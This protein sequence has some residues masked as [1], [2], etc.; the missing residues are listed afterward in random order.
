MKKYLGILIWFACLLVSC[1]MPSFKNSDSFDYANEAAMFSYAPFDSSRAVDFI[2][3]TK[4]ISSSNITVSWTYFPGADKYIIERKTEAG[5]WVRIYI[6]NKSERNFKDS[7]SNG[8]MENIDYL[9]R[10]CA[11]SSYGEKSAYSDVATGSLLSAPLNVNVTKGDK[12]TNGIKV[13]W[14]KVDGITTYNIMMKPNDNGDFL[15]WHKV[16]TVK[17]V[18]DN[19]DAY[20]TFVI[21]DE[22][23]SQYEG[24]EL[25][26]AVV[27]VS[28]SNTSNVSNLSGYRVG[29]SY[30]KGA[31]AKVTG[32]S[33]EKGIGTTPD[34]GIKISFD[35][36]GD[37]YDY[38]IY[39]S[40]PGSD[41][42]K[43]YPVYANQPITRT[44]GKVEFVDNQG[45]KPDT[46]IRYTYSIIATTENSEGKTLIGESSTEIGYL[47]SPPEDIQLSEIVYDQ[48]KGYGFR[49]SMNA[50]VGLETATE[51]DE[52]KSWKINIYGWNHEKNP[53]ISGEKYTENATSDSSSKRLALSSEIKKIN[54][55]GEI[56]VSAI[57]EIGKC[58]ATVYF[59]DEK[60]DSFTFTISSTE[61]GILKESLV[62]KNNFEWRGPVVESAF[63]SQNKYIGEANVNGIYPIEVSLSLAKYGLDYL[64]SFDVF[65]DENNSSLIAKV[66]NNSNPDSNK[67][68]SVS[69]NDN[70]WEI[71][72]KY[73][74]WLKIKD[75]FGYETK[76]KLEEGY[77]A[78]TGEKLI[79]RFESVV[80]KPWENQNYVPEE[81]K[82]YWANSEIG[83][84]IKRGY[85][86]KLSEQLGAL[87]DGKD[88]SDNDHSSRSGMVIYNAVA[89]G[90]GGKVSFAYRNFGESEYIYGNGKYVMHVNSSGDENQS[91]ISDSQTTGFEIGGLYPCNIYLD[92]IKVSGKK[93]AGSYLVDLKYSNKKI[94]KQEIGANQP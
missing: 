51:R 21:D 77:G 13:S 15:E 14:D 74:F 6:A 78:I 88:I 85:S 84:K 61:T 70:S 20:Y 76:V 42:S 27:S 56:D 48:D 71:G 9:Y 3:A 68:S 69:F 45:V 79:A 40:S 41:E 34:D 7:C 58:N 28:P 32:L 25:R 93:F 53:D 39:R 66:G 65:T 44:A 67:V 82:T 90:V 49:I 26:F 8:L 86:S 12:N 1:D 31:P 55:L 72:K 5:E 47:L 17:A 60:L 10:V 73:D 89:E 54:K 37:A 63:A 91:L 94:E 52:H 19:D 35:D 4:N 36:Q 29:Y 50:P 22:T 46:G 16:E 75:V 2:N 83:E 62:S 11:V 43:V 59:G 30:V 80:L 24:S 38:L 81:Y 57:D 64:D 87:T 23:N 92:K 18:N 33:I